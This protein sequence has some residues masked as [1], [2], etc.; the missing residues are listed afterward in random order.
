MQVPA[1]SYDFRAP[2]S[3]MTLSNRRQQ[4]PR[5]VAD[6]Q[7]SWKIRSADPGL[8]FETFSKLLFPQQSQTASP[9]GGHL[10]LHNVCYQPP[11]AASPLLDNVSMELKSNEMGLICG[12][13]GS[14]KTTLLQ[15]ITGLSEQSSGTV[16][17]SNEAPSGSLLIHLCTDFWTGVCSRGCIC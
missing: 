8:V 15:V 9:S 5:C 10:K 16:S 17:I 3:T 11:E 6:R 2:K 13:S 7:R 14:G 4:T 12:K 1:I